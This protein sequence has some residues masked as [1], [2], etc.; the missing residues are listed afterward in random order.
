MNIGT[1]VPHSTFRTP[2]PASIK[3]FSNVRLQPSRKAIVAPEVAD[4]FPLLD[5][6]AAMGRRGSPASRC[7]GQRP[8]PNGR[9]PGRQEA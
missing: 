5:Q 8:G 7:V 4:F 3:A 9:A 2:I 1:R 6:L